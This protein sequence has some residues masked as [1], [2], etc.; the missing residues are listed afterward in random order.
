MTYEKTFIKPLDGNDGDIVYN[1]VTTHP[2]LYGVVNPN[3]FAYSHFYG[4]YDANDELL[5]FFAI[6]RWDYGAESVLACVY[7]FPKNRRKGI[8]KKMVKFFIEHSSESKLLTIGARHE[9]ELANKIYDKMFT[10]A[11]SEEEGN[12]YIIRDRRY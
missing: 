2:E 4:V 11:K 3:D 7:V 5:G 10:F 12:F 1:I 6:C 9:N 8:F